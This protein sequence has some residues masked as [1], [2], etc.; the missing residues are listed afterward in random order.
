MSYQF[1]A[2]L[3]T[4]LERMVALST[5]AF[6]AEPRPFDPAAD[7]SRSEWVL[8]AGDV[9]VAQATDIQFDSWFGGSRLAT[10]GIG[11]V[12]VAP[13]YRGTGAAKQIMVASL[14][15]AHARGAV[16][17]T[18]FGGA[19]GLYRRLGYELVASSK[20]W[21][22]PLAALR[23]IDRPTTIKLRRATAADV[24]ELRQLHNRLAAEGSGMVDRTVGAIA[25]SGAQTTVAI[26]SF[27]SIMGALVWSTSNR[28]RGVSVH[29]SDLRVSSVD[30]LRALLSSLATWGSVADIVSVQAVDDEP[31]RLL[32]GGNA[33]PASVAPYMLRVLDVPGAISGRG[34]NPRVEGSVRIRVDDDV[35]EQNSGVWQLVATGGRVVVMP[36]SAEPDLTLT[37]RGLALWFSGV[38]RCAALRPLDLLVDGSDVTDALL[39]D[40]AAAPPV[41]VTEYF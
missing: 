21:I 41:L 28:G 9:L 12:V 22:V 30:A 33:E 3:P 20:K 2:A 31:F 10:A 38:T 23:G 8:E 19:P 16:L 11:N 24:A 13:E 39:D 29:V 15:R 26:D 1:R 35:I 14:Q 27:G 5:E 18:L 17:S 37:L 6:A 7:R 34:W 36:T 40:L 4:D 32:L 25:P